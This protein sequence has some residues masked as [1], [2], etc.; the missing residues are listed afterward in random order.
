M[1]T[2][3]K[4]ATKKTTSKA[5]GT[6]KPKAASKPRANTS[7]RAA[8]GGEKAATKRPKAKNATRANQAAQ[9]ANPGKAAKTK[10]FSLLDAAAK[11]LAEHT[12][13]LRSREMVKIV[14]EKGLWTPGAGKTPHASLYAAII[15]EISAKGKNARFAK[16]ERGLFVHT[17]TTGKGAS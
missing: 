12:D 6:S 2:T 17:G 5:K 11:V 9:K 7:P 14:I 3:T 8:K 13:G 10:K 16:A 4:K 15:R 1:A